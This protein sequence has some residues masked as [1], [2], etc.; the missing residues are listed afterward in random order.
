MEPLFLEISNDQQINEMESL[1]MN[2]Q[3]NG[4]TRMMFTKIPHFKEICVSSFDCPHC[5]NRNN[6]VQF[7]HSLSDEGIRITLDVQNQQD[8]NRQVVISEFSTINLS[9]ISLE[10]P[11]I[12]NKTTLTTIEGILDKCLS[13]MIQIIEINKDA[14]KTFIDKITEIADNLRNFKNNNVPFT[15]KFDDP[16]GNSYVQK[17]SEDDPSVKIE[18]YERNPEDM[19][20]FGFA[21]ENEVNEELDD[22]VN[23]FST[24]CPNCH[25]HCDTR[26]CNVDVP[27][28]K[29]V[30]IMSTK[31]EACGYVFNEIKSGGAI[32]AKG[33]RIVFKITSEADL[34]RD[35]IKSDS[36]SLEILEIDLKIMNGT[37]GSQ[38]TTIE[39]ILLDIHRDL[40]QKIPFST[41]DSADSGSINRV[42]EIADK[43]RLI[44]QGKMN[45]TI[46]LDDPLAN[47]YIQNIYAPDSDPEMS[48]TEYERDYEQNEMFGL[49]DIDTEERNA[50]DSK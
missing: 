35:F 2:C 25:V 11:P 47:S 49:N 3:E 6:S 44:S 10:I 42:K 31:C 14:E 34:A 7:L 5:G 22:R 41:G 32:P 17:Y 8:L 30:L 38:F 23:T 50:E 16:S 15:L 24:A 37:L 9:E 40:E 45:C 26:M 20:K 43:V 36:C 19:K 13:D 46:V 18:M 12:A 1:C 28:F 29:E 27:H 39:G 33:R 48:I 21:D 4:T